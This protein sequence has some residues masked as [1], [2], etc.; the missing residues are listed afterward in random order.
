[1]QR[2]RRDVIVGLL[3]SIAALNTVNELSLSLLSDIITNEIPVSGEKVPAVGLGSWITF[4]V[5][6][7][8]QAIRGIADIMQTFFSEGGRLVDSSPMY[9]SSQDVIGQALDEKDRKNLIAIDKVWTTGATDG[10]RQIRRSRLRWGV[11]GFSL[12]QVHNLLDWQTHLPT[13]FEMKAEGVLKY[14][15]VTT[16]HGR[17]HSELERIM[18]TQP[19]DFIQLTYNMIDRTAEA[20]ILPLAKE[21]GIAVIANRPLGGGRLIRRVKRQTLP[22]EAIA[23][24][25]SEWSEFLLKWIISHPSLTCAIPAT[26]QISHLRENM[27]ACRGAKPD[28]DMRRRMIE[29]VEAL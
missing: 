28:V 5:G 29:I 23:L 27:L 26:S 15:G 9:G 13:L 22:T 16:S 6:D 21:R 24:G 25:F 2:S 3:S 12:L 8:A 7:D 4:N 14:V 11:D 17:R 1:M 20:R 10:I 18:K 19:I